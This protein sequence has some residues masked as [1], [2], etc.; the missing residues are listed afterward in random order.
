MTTRLPAQTDT[1]MVNRNIHLEQVA[2]VMGINIDLL[3]SLNPMYRRDVVP[4]ATEL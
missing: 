1:I 2:E 3:R 4:G